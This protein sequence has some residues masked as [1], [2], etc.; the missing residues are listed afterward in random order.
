M[1]YQR[2]IIIMMTSGE[3]HRIIQVSSGGI[4]VGVVSIFGH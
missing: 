2:G 1:L 3:D 4:Y